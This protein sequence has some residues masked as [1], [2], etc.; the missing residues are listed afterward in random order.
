MHSINYVD[1]NIIVNSYGCR[2]IAINAL[3]GKESFTLDDLCADVPTNGGKYTAGGFGSHPPAL[4][5]KGN[6]WIWAIG[7]DG[8][9]TSGGRSFIAGVDATTKKVAWRF[10]IQ[11]PQGAKFPAERAAW[12][13][14][15]VDNCK[16]IWIQQISACDIPQDI[17]RNDW[18]TMPINAGISN[19]WGQIAVDEDSGI[20]YLG[21][22]QAGPDFNATGLDGKVIPGPRLFGASVIALNAKSGQFLWAH[23]T[24]ARDLWDW[25]C[26]WNTIIAE[27]TVKGQKQKVVMKGCKNGKIHAF[28]PLTGEAFW[29][30]DPPQIKRAKFSNFLDP[31]NAQDMVKPWQNYPSTEPYFQNCPSNGCIESDIA[32]DPT[33]NTLY[34]GDSN[35]LL[36]AKPTPINQI[37]DNG[38]Q[39]L[40]YPTGDR[41]QNTTILAIDVNTGTI[42]WTFFRDKAAFRGGV[43]VSNGVVYFNLPAEGTLYMLDADTGKV[44]ATKYYG[45]ATNVQPSIG[46]TADGKIRVFQIIGGNAVLGG[47]FGLGAQVPGALV[48]LGLPDKPIEPVIKEVVKEVQVPKE[49]IKEVTKEVTKTVTVE[50]VSPI[51]YAIIGVGVVFLVIGGVLFSRRKKA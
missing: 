33:R 7:G 37:G 30:L 43:F 46:A 45:I 21:T 1:G 32:F 15:L 48:A 6:M 29:V 25:D 28:N 5:K 26:S 13:Q 35:L 12:G 40:P 4:Y 8:E 19:V 2:V 38:R 16:K 34:V 17:L 11:P 50:T 42:K 18:G 51:S 20:V 39:E 23:Q 36:Y 3:T 10:F 49:V 44:L 14:F 47:R 22:A 9:G 27:T 31:K 41:P 24:T